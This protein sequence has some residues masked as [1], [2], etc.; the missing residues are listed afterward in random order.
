MSAMRIALYTNIMVYAEG[1]NGEA[2]KQST[3]SLMEKLPQ[4]LIVLPV[5]AGWVY[6]ERG[7]HRQSIRVFASPFARRNDSEIMRLM[8]LSCL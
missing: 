6:L 2:K 7:H 8:L 1:L 3:L 5:H 4:D